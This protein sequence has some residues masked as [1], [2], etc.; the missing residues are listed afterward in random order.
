MAPKRHVGCHGSCKD[1]KIERADLDES[2]RA[3]KDHN[4]EADAYMLD[5][6]R[7]LADEN[8]KSGGYT[9]GRRSTNHNGK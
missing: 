6:S 3:H 8:R 7:R 5:K 4:Y 2:L 9:Y 1:Y